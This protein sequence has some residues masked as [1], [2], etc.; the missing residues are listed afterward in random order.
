MFWPSHL[1]PI[2]PFPHALPKWEVASS[3][4][5]LLAVTLA[6]LKYRESRYL[7]VGWFWFVG[8]MVPMIGLVQ[9]GNQAMADRYAYLPLVGVFVM[10]VW[11]AGE[12]ASARHIDEKYLAAAGLCVLCALSAVTRIQIGYWRDGFTLWTHTLAVSPHNFVAENNLGVTLIKSG[13]GDEAIPHFRTAAQLE[14]GDPTSQLNLGIYAQEHGD[15]RQAA[16]RYE[17]VL[18]LTSNAQLRASAYGNLGST[19]FALRDYTRAQ[20]SY[21]SALK[22]NLVTP[23]VLRDL[24]L[25]AQK[26]GDW[27]RAI[28][29][30]ARLVAAEP[31]D[32]GYLLLSHAL[33]QG[34]REQEAKLS[35][36]QALRF[37]TDINQAQKIADQLMTE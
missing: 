11:A 31:S 10:I 15:L 8:S 1:V 23:I 28:Y 26:S 14:P 3:A 19:Y 36:H 4:V 33:E 16:A 12:L 5:L 18:Q 35:Y 32:V 22:L 9:V 20:Q 34:N 30:F 7:F 24:G 2:Y 21:E 29:Y 13:K 6:V 37:S 27:N 25:I 17:S